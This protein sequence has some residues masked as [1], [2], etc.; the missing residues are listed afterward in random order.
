MLCYKG[1]SA[2]IGIDVWVRA[3]V[4]NLKQQLSQMSVVETLLPT[5]MI[6]EQ[7]KPSWTHRHGFREQD[8]N[9]KCQ[10]KANFDKHHKV[11]SLPQ[12]PQQAEVWITTDRSK[13]TPGVVVE[14]AEAPQS[15]LVE[16]HAEWQ[17]M[18]QSTPTQCHAYS[19]VIKTLAEPLGTKIE[20]PQQLEQPQPQPEGEQLPEKGDKSPSPLRIMTQSQTGTIR[21]PEQLGW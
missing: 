16:T 17:D 4:A 19:L 14:K 21:P 3:R 7:L 20:Q 13:P 5:D 12:I 2:S 1:D 11:P 18:P 10:Q 6:S 15:Y 9:F 8:H